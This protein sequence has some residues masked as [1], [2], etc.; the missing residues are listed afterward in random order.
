[1]VEFLEGLTLFPVVLT[2]GA[3]FLGQ[4]CQKKLKTPLCN[5][6]LI[7]VI[8]VLLVLGCTGMELKAYQAGTAWIS[9]LMTPP[10]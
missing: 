10:P 3:F 8:L 6:I 4:W 9:W 2:L 5:P 1:M 7:A